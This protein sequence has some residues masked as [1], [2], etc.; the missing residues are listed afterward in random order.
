MCHRAGEQGADQEH[1]AER[2]TGAGQ[3]LTH[4]QASPLAL[5]KAQPAPAPPAANSPNDAAPLVAQQCD[6]A[7]HDG[8]ACEMHIHDDDGDDVFDAAEVQLM[9][10]AV[11]DV[12][13]SLKVA[14][15]RIDDDAQQRVLEHNERAEQHRTQ[16]TKSLRTPQLGGRGLQRR[17]LTLQAAAGADAQPPVQ[18][19]AH[20][21]PELAAH[22]PGNNGDD[23]IEAVQ[24]DAAEA[25]NGAAGGVATGV[26]ALVASQ[27][28][29]L[30]RPAFGKKRQGAEEASAAGTAVRPM[31]ALSKTHAGVGGADHHEDDDGAARDHDDH[32]QACS[33]CPARKF[34]L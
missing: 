26:D 24:A 15:G 20:A 7:W 19:A 21:D 9:P 2:L 33:P 1:T 17:T 25:G 13:G 18:G 8:D 3:A 28:R 30:A 6:L 4:Q 16:V 31:L 11:E 22:H 14:A 23:A 29:P 5:R 34:V 12:A 32:D 27:R 10:K